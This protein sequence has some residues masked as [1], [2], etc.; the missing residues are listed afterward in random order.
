MSLLKT[1]PTRFHAE[2][3]D[4]RYKMFYCRIDGID[5]AGFPSLTI[6]AGFRSRVE[7]TEGIMEEFGAPALS[8]EDIIS[9]LSAQEKAA[10]KL[11]L[12]AVEREVGAK[13][14]DLDGATQD[15]DL[16]S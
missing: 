9:G 13:V 2:D 15:D 10:G 8:R 11:F 7:G 4:V 16:L 1:K 14:A 6:N 12:K 5:E 3:Q